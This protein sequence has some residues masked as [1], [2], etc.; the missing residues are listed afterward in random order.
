MKTEDRDYLVEACAR[1]AASEDVP[2]T[3]ATLTTKGEFL[4]L[5]QTPANL[6]LFET[7]DAQSKPLSGAVTGVFTGGCA[8]SGFTSA[9]GAPTLCATGPVGAHAHTP[10]EYMVIDTIAPRAIALVMTIG[11]LGSMSA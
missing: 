10:D 7:Y 3:S 6:A 1:I 11:A 8:D 2:G 5:E 4:P 9:V